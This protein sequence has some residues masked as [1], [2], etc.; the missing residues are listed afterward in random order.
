M[1]GFIILATIRTEKRTLVF[2]SMSQHK[3]L[4]KSMECEIKVKGTG[5]RCLLVE[6]VKNNYYARYHNPS[7]HKYRETHLSILLHIST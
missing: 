5:S 2:Y 7:Y 1:Q 6:Y 3:I 4:T